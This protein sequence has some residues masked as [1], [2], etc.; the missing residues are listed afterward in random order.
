MRTILPSFLLAMSM[1]TE[2][3]A[4]SYP[5][6]E[7]LQHMAAR[8]APTVL[9]ADTSHLGAGDLAAL[10]KLLETGPLIDR[11][12]LE[13]LWSG[14]LAQY[15]K[16]RAD[17]T[18]LGR[19]RFHMFWLSKGPWSDLDEHKAFLP[20]VPER[21]PLGAN[22]YPAD[23]TTVEFEKWVAQLPGEQAKEATSFFTVIRRDPG[24]RR[25]KSIP[26]YEA[27][28][29]YLKPAAKLLREAAALTT[30]E[31]LKRFLQ[32]RADAF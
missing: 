28:G 19:A 13:Q 25:L 10:K 32:L 31:S 20:G 29:E 27:Y 18:A 3:T 8:F 24:T 9:S 21:K 30:N 1:L 26:Y 11:I 15:E 23:M 17:D 5:D 12:F 7:Q 14:N 2:L 4:A 22:F 16:L 6:T